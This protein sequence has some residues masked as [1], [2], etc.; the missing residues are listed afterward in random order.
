MKSL[1]AAAILLSTAA[2]ALA[3]SPTDLD[4]AKTPNGRIVVDF[5]DMEFNQHKP[6]EAFD[7]HVGAGFVNRFAGGPH[8][9]VD[10]NFAGQK[11]AETKVFAGSTSLTLAI[12]K[13]LAQG[14]LVF[15]QGMAKHDPT[16]TGNQV[17]MLFRLKEGKIVEHWDLH[18]GLPENSDPDLYF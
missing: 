7:K 17:W 11:A 1:I 10:N 3:A 5:V 8:V 16:S 13:V 9:I 14:D 12:K 6:A 18:A 2:S 15:V 4:G